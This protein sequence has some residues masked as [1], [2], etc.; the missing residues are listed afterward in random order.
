MRWENVVRIDGMTRRVMIVNFIR[1][2]V[3]ALTPIH[4]HN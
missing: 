1:V 3:D 4:V 2:N